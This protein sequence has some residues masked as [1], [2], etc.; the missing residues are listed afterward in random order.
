VIGLDPFQEEILEAFFAREDGFFVTGGAALAGFHLHH[1]PATSLALCTLEDR[2]RVGEAALL[3]VAADIGAKAQR[4][5]AP[6]AYGRFLLRRGEDSAVVE[7]EQ[8]LCPQVQPEKTLI[9]AV[10]VDRPKEIT[11]RILCA[12]RSHYDL[13]DIVDLRA[14]EIAGHKV[15]D[16]LDAAAHRNPDVT[17][18]ALVKALSEFE[19]GEGEVPPGDVTAADIRSYVAVLT[20]RLSSLATS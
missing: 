5:E 16:H 3:E 14:L 2:V 17:P 12:L 9:G 20:L 6:E 7:L 10:R 11:A 15:E 1:R 19:I 18:A 13:N 4:L 8:D